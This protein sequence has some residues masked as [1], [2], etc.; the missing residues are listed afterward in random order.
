MVILDLECYLRFEFIIW[1]NKVFRGLFGIDNIFN[2]LK[3]GFIFVSNY[4]IFKN[5]FSLLFDF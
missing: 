5:D 1:Y 2:K 3:F 4:K